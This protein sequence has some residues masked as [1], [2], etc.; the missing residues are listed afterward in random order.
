MS[1]CT[2]K[3][4]TGVTIGGTFDFS[5][6]TFN[7]CT[8]K[9]Y[10]IKDAVRESTF[11][12]CTISDV[13]L[14]SLVTGC[15]FDSCK[16]R[17]I[18]RGETSAM[19]NNTFKNMN[20]TAFLPMLFGGI[21]SL[22]LFWW[23]INSYEN[24]TVSYQALNEISLKINEIAIN[25]HCYAVGYPGF[26]LMIDL[27]NL[28]PLLKTY[29]IASTFTMS[30][31]FDDDIENG[32]LYEALKKDQRSI[33]VV[34]DLRMVLKKQDS[35]CR[36]V[37]RTG[38]EIIHFQ[39]SFDANIQVEMYTSGTEGLNFILVW[40]PTDEDLTPLISNDIK[41]PYIIEPHVD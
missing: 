5:Y 28:S 38:E 6:S 31:E 36:V 30:A 35:S 18:E 32:V 39:D 10:Y 27:R 9:N 7:G 20:I 19:V 16:V 14:H 40:R 33:M 2:E 22:P 24:T 21:K 25:G 37:D 15:T 26:R 23:G 3:S 8:I 12:G 34:N 13:K 4:Y 41:K 11:V 1:N 17:W 29:L